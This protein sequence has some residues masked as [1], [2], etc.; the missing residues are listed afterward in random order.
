ML[1]THLEAPDLAGRTQPSREEAPLGVRDGKDD[2]GD[3]S[4]NNHT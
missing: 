2:P 3:I 4:K 1:K